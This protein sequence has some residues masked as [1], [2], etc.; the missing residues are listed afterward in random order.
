MST[1]MDIYREAIAVIESDYPGQ[2]ALLLA[3]FID[4]NVPHSADG[5][6]YERR[7]HAAL[8]DLCKIL[9][10]NSLPRP[11]GMR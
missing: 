5:N 2:A 10:H 1:Q 9:D 3:D 6:D 4:H 7:V 8:V 11:P